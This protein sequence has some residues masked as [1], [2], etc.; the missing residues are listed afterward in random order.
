MRIYIANLVTQ[1]SLIA[2]DLDRVE[3]AQ[4]AHPSLLKLLPARPTFTI[5]KF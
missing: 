1:W 3:H 4:Q 2:P 5:K